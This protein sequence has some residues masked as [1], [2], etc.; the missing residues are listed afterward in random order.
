MTSS[1]DG[2]VALV[3][4]AS[5]GIGRAI[6]LLLL[7]RGMMVAAS[8]RRRERLDDLAKKSRELPGELLSLVVDQRKAEE[9]EALI[10]KVV[11]RW[12]ALDV[13]VNNAGVSGGKGLLEADPAQIQDCL[14]LNVRAAILCMR[15]A[16]A[17]MR[18]RGGVIINIGSMAGHRQIPGRIGSVGYSA[19]KHALRA[20]TEGLRME[21]VREK[22]PVKVALVSPGLVDTEWHAAH[23]GTGGAAYPYRPLDP[24]DVA[25]A[26]LYILSTPP[27]AQVCDLQLRST[28]QET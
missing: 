22:I 8:G 5:S 19:S 7:E 25:S 20:A 13:L 28:E 14:D 6:A 23:R 9:N 10:E 12:G 3:T 27:H 26:A 1:L 21:L 2:K 18:E 16:V 11:E 4:G 15:A 17:R 24:E